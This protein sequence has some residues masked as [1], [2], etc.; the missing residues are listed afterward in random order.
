MLKR[1]LKKAFSLLLAASMV[2]AMA[3]C[4][5]G[6]AGS[7]EQETNGGMDAAGEKA[8]DV[9][10][11][12]DG[13]VAM[14]RYVEEE[15]DLSEQLQQPS[16]MSRLADGSLVIMDKSAG[17]LVSKDE[18]ATWTAEMP[19]WFAELKANETYISSMYMGPD[20]TAAVITAESS[21]E[22]DDMTVI[23]HLSLYLP[24]GTPVPVEKEMT[25]DEKYFKQVA[26]KEDGTILASTYRGV[27]EVQQDGSCEQILTLDYNPQWMWVRDNLL[28]G[29]H[30][31]SSF[32]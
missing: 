31:I 16:S 10:T 15:I 3:G 20:G 1:N 6:G 7:G 24:D 2:F 27:Y 29:S 25:E 5:A 8:Q 9:T 13:P 18:G 19:D 28:V 26:F 21:G 17:M 11:G 12:G 22:G 30:V 14:G 4:G 32:P 23:Q